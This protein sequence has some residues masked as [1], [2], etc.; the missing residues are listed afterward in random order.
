MNQS[1]RKTQ[2]NTTVRIREAV[3]MHLYL[4]FTHK[5]TAQEPLPRTV[6]HIYNDIH[7][8]IQQTIFG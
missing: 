8:S 5:R 6:A 1:F 4:S 3:R 7:L 2:H